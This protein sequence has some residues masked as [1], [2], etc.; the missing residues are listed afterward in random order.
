MWTDE[1]IKIVGHF[2]TRHQQQHPE[3]I[4]VVSNC[5]KFIMA[6]TNIREHFHPHHIADSTRLRWGWEKFKQNK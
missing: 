3:S 1:E 2:C 6:D 5:L 4:N